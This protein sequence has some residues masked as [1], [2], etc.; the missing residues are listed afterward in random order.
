MITENKNLIEAAK[1][2]SVKLEELKDKLE[3][4]NKLPTFNCHTHIFN[5]DYV[6]DKFIKGMFSI[7][8]VFLLCAFLLIIVL[9][10]LLL[11]QL[12]LGIW[13]LNILHINSF[14]FYS[15]AGTTVIL[16]ILF[17]FVRKPYITIGIKW[18]RRLE[19]MNKVTPSGQL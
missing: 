9:A 15:L 1:N 11:V 5:F 3:K 16:L 13:P 18:L 4:D 19:K 12:I 7:R 2:E 17:V 8:F 6:H 10:I 14:V